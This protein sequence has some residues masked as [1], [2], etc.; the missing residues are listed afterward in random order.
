MPIDLRKS[1]TNY[2]A[3]LKYERNLS[4]LTIK[5][6]H[7]DLEQFLRIVGDNVE[8]EELTKEFVQK[9]IRQLFEKHLGDTSIRRKA[10]CVKSFLSFL[11]YERVI[12]ENPF[13][14]MRFSIKIPKKIPEVMN[15]EEIKSLLGH[16]RKEFEEKSGADGKNGRHIAQA[17][18][19]ELQPLQHLVILEIL[20]CTGMRVSELSSLNSDDIDLVRNIIKI[21]GKGSKQRIAPI[22]NNQVAESLA[23]FIKLRKK[24]R[25]KAKWLL[26]NR[27]GRRMSAQSIRLIIKN[28]VRSLKFG[29]RIT[30]HTFRHTTATMLLENGTDIRYVQSLLGHASILT[31]QIYTHVS[32]TA[33][34]KFITLNHPRNQ[35]K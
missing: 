4:P 22:P 8:R 33:Q 15:L 26:Q 17:R 20:F 27:L 29:K 30:P 1:S 14:K 2:L 10:I 32:E 21:N 28:D 24:G 18:F 31:T 6:Y 35:L 9:Y 13:H 11:E 19:A 23:L 12:E 25:R 34:R 7:L 3:S 5:A 16:S